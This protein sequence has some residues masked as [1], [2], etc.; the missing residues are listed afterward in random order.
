MAKYL[1]ALS[2]LAL[3]TSPARAEVISATD[4]GFQVSHSID[5]PVSPERAYATIIVPS[6]WWSKDHSWSGNARNMTIDARAG[7][8]FCEALVPG[9]GSVEHGRVIYADPGKVLRLQSALGPL[10]MIG[11]VNG[12]LTFEISPRPRGS[13]SQVTVRYF[14]GGY[15]PGGL[16]SMASAVD[17]VLGEQIARLGKALA[18]PTP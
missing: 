10:Q 5:L 14:V 16:K 2:T 3:A 12:V 8:C 15:A 11:A 6:R 9:K 4:N 18:A 13:G 1:L 17:R 7:G